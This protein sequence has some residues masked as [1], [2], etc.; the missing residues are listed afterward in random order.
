MAL[1][2]TIRYSVYRQEE[3]FKAMDASLVGIQ[4]VMSDSLYHSKEVH[5]LISEMRNWQKVLPLQGITKVETD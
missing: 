4:N 2:N 1:I 5:M 3:V